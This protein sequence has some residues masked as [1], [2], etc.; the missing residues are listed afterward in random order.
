VQFDDG[1]QLLPEV[2]MET[3]H[4]ANEG[5]FKVMASSGMEA[6]ALRSAAYLVSA[7]ADP[8][9]GVKHISDEVR[10]CIQILSGELD[11]LGLLEQYRK[12]GKL[13][14]WDEANEVDG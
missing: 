2:R 14:A 11:A 5:T 13:I 12:E 8:R 4:Q 7:L 3:H 10:D 9:F 1:S 6:Q